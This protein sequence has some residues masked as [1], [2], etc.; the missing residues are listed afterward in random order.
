MHVDLRLKKKTSLAL[1]GREAKTE[2]AM[3]YHVKQDTRKVR[4]ASVSRKDFGWAGQGL[5][6]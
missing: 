1:K 3:H 2:T 5:T 4:K 6:R